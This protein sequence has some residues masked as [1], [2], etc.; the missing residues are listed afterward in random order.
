MVQSFGQ[1]LRGLKEGTDF[2]HVQGFFFFFAPIALA[3]SE[4]RIVVV[5]VQQGN[6]PLPLL[7][8]RQGDDG[9]DHEAEFLQVVVPGVIVDQIL[10][11]PFEVFVVCPFGSL[12]G[13]ASGHYQRPNQ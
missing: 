13:G 10:M 5:L 3:Q 9:L 12:M 1:A 2:R 4:V 8:L 7:P 6:D 11:D